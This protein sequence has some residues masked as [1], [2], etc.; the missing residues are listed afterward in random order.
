MESPVITIMFA[1]I[2]IVSI[3][4]LVHIC[5]R[6]KNLSFSEYFSTKPGSYAGAAFLVLLA[7]CGVVYVVYDWEY[8]LDSM[9]IL[10]GFIIGII[11]LF[12]LGLLSAIG[13]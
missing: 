12:V 8:L 13:I 5:I 4:L 11:V 6:H 3:S 2:G 7:I 9:H 10:I 1:T